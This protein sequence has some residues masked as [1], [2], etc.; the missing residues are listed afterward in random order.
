MGRWHVL[1][2]PSER[3]RTIKE[4]GVLGILGEVLR[5]QWVAHQG[6]QADVK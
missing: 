1:S 6:I 3:N 4:K 2:T 5:L